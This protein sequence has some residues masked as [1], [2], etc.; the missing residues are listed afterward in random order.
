MVNQSFDIYSLEH[1][2]EYRIIMSAENQQWIDEQQESFRQWVPDE[3]SYTNKILIAKKQF[4]KKYEPWQKW[5]AMTNQ[6]DYDMQYIQQFDK[7]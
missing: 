1:E 3:D 4:D 2:N 5:H 7:A 6:K